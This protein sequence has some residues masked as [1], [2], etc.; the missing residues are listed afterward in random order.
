[1]WGL[2]PHYALKHRWHKRGLSQVFGFVENYL[3]LLPASPSAMT[4]GRPAAVAF[5]VFD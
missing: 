1:M 2:G 5:M 4:V 3:T